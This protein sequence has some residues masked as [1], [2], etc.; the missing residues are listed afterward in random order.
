[1]RFG[2]VI[3][4][5]A[6]LFLVTV[7][8]SYPL[9]IVLI[10]TLGLYWGP[11]IGASVSVLLG[12]LTIGYVFSGKTEDGRKEAIAKISVL[13]TVLM[14]FS[15]VLNNAVLGED[16]T[17]WVHETYQESNPT[18]SLTAFEW[19]LVGGLFIGSQ[20][21][22]NVIILFLFSLIGLFAGSM[23]RKTEKN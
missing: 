23:L 16:F 7:L 12:A 9:E 14:V 4:A 8:I 5:V 21:F 20:M 1:L 3:T 17:H 2:D 6:S 11:T 15:I 19:F 13:F 18:S 22:M 10:S